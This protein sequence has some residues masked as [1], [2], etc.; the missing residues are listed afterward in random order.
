MADCHKLLLAYNSDDKGISLSQSKRDKL[1][2]AR[3]IIENKIKNSDEYE[4]SDYIIDFRP[5]G[6]FEMDTI[7]NPINSDDSYDI[8]HGVYFLSDIEPEIKP[9]TLKS[10]I[11]N[12]LENHTKNVSN[13]KNCIRV[14]YAVSS[15]LPTYHIDIPVYWQKKEETPKLASSL[16]WKESD[17]LQFVDW[18]NDMNKETKNQLIRITRNFK[19]WARNLNGS[20]PSGIILTVL[21]AYNYHKDERDDISFYQTLNSI[22]CSLSEDFSCFRP[23]IPTDEDLFKGYSDTNKEYFLER[24]KGFL[25][26]S[27]EALETEDI[28]ESANLWNNIFG[29]KFS[30]ITKEFIEGTKM[31]ENI[32]QNKISVLPSGVLSNN[33]SNVKVSSTKFYGSNAI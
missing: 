20:M 11:F 32:K 25:K 17:P 22:F 16:G 13:K 18:F 19:W 30:S 33:E 15:D 10:W 21:A 14:A 26:K 2:N 28:E 12:V 4:S 27:N 3:I 9:S 31:N 23:T 29:D 1:S 24:L 8:D 7:I 5:Q 6:S